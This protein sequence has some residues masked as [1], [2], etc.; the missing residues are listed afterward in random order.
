M[1][2]RL[3]KRL[4]R[5][6]ELALSLQFA[7]AAHRALLP[8]HV[9]VRW[10]CHALQ[11]PGQITV[12]VVGAEEGL[13]LNSEFRGQQHATN[14]ITFDYQHEPVVV[15]D[16]VLCAPVVA[17]E[18]RRQRTDLTAHYAH[19]VVHGTLHAQGFDHLN[20]ADAEAME[21][22]ESRVM[23]GLGFKDPYRRRR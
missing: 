11:R 21:A 23:L 17:A 19:L 20:D 9:V 16:L 4:L 22:Q 6:P 15:A 13:A 5:R 1:T 12:R 14:V 2:K 7:D 8:R 18:A 10:I 3:H